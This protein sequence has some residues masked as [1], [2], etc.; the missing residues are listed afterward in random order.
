MRTGCKAVHPLASDKSR[1]WIHRNSELSYFW[2]RLQCFHTV[3]FK[4]L[5]PERGIHNTKDLSEKDMW[6]PTTIEAPTYTEREGG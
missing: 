3:K 2:E 6:K 4:I 1:L 5:S